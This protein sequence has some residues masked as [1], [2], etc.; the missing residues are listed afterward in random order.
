MIDVR[1]SGEVAQGVIPTS[2]HVPL[3]NI[4]E[5]LSLPEKEFE[6]RF[7]EWIIFLS[8]YE[9]RQSGGSATVMKLSMAWIHFEIHIEGGQEGRVGISSNSHVDLLASGSSRRISG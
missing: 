8:L 2:H 6:A 9:V 4:Q 3:A 1:E 7:G 5:A